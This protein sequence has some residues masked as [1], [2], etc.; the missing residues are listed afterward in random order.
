M[1]LTGAAIGEII[2]V[3]RGEAL[4]PWRRAGTVLLE[5]PLFSDI[6]IFRLRARRNA[7]AV[8]PDRHR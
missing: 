4:E 3:A 5:S 6:L 2:A 1:G 8:T 7:G